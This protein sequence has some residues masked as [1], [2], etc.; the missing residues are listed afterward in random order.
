MS[1]LQ[2]AIR[3]WHTVR[4]L[5][6]IQVYGRIWFRLYRPRPDVTPAPPLRRRERDWIACARSP[7]Q[8]GPTVFRFIGQTHTLETATDWNRPDWPKLWL[9]N[10]HYFDDLVADGAQKRSEWHRASIMQWIQENPPG[11]GNGWDPYPTSLRI[12]NWLKWLAAGNGPVEGMIDSLAVQARWLRKRLEHHLLGNHLWANLEAMIFAGTAFEGSEADAWRNL[13]LRLLRRELSEQVLADGGHFERSPMYHAI[14]LED[15]L[16]LIQLSRCFPGILSE[17]DVQVWQRTATKMLRWLQAM[18]HP[19]GGITFFNDAALDI[20][21]GVDAL[22]I[23]AGAVGLDHRAPEFDR[24]EHFE[25]SGYLRMAQGN[26]VAFLDLAPIGPD[27][28]PGHAH[29]D[30]LS[31]ELSIGER[32]VLVN[33]G[34]STYEDGDE[35]ANERATTMHNTVVVDGQDSSETWA[36]FRVARRAQVSDVQ[37]TG[38]KDS[39]HVEARHDGY[40]RLPGRVVHR[41]RWQMDSV[42]LE[43]LD[44]LEGE[45][46]KARAFF[47]LAPGLRAEL[48]GNCNGTIEGAD[49]L[50]RWQADGCEASIEPGEWHPEFGVSTACEV[51]VLEA[52]SRSFSIRFDWQ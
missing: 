46:S 11:S 14:L 37:V 22:A 34:T 33:G 9:Y 35:R 39:C 50:I 19:D 41:R 31:F 12:V 2:K 15:L 42:G 10:L 48:L 25:D 51:L 52:S 45:F 27:Y 28:L 20:A 26:A 43:V 44:R 24:I 18:S 8:L 7:R 30:T 38:E 29:A 1:S 4:H 21:P 17:E 49:L 13:G 16:D 47:R 40:R 6:P 36:S 5:R 23:H 3:Y 32:R